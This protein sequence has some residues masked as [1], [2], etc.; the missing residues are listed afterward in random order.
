MKYKS[1]S[2]SL[3]IHS[4]LWICIALLS[5][6]SA[7]STAT[8]IHAEP[9]ALYVAPEPLGKAGAVGTREEP[10]ASVNAALQRVA[11]SPEGGRVILRGGRYQSA[12]A[13]VTQ[14]AKDG[15]AP[16]VII[17]GAEGESPILDGSLS[18][19][20]AASFPDAK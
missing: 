3:L 16:P 7:M 1:S 12:E 5:A 17:E 11:E 4:H 10:W 6:L 8:N 9:L 2:V 19:E 15:S 20:K 14:K 13:Q 18:T